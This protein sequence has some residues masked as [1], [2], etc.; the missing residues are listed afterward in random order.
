MK[1][2]LI[3]CLMITLFLGDMS[4]VYAKETVM[5]PEEEKITFDDQQ[6]SY[7]KKKYANI[8]KIYYFYSQLDD[9]NQEIYKALYQMA[10]D[11]NVDHVYSF[12]IKTS[13]N[14]A[15]AIR[16]L[17]K[18]LYLAEFAVALDHP[19][20]VTYY[21]NLWNKKDYFDDDQEDPIL[22]SQPSVENGYI[23]SGVYY[24]SH[25]KS[26]KKEE[27]QLKE[28]AIQFLDTRIN[29]DEPPA[30]IAKQ[31]HDELIDQV[32]YDNAAASLSTISLAHT[33]FGALHNRRAVC[34]GYALAYEYL[35]Q[36]EGITACVIYGSVST[37]D[38]MQEH[39]WNET[40]LGDDWYETDVTWDD[41]DDLKKDYTYYNLTSEQMASRID[42]GVVVN[43]KRDDASSDGTAQIAPQAKGTHFSKAYMVYQNY[44][45]DGV[46]PLGNP[47]SYFSVNNGNAIALSSDL[48]QTEWTITLQEKSDQTIW[49]IETQVNNAFTVEQNWQNGLL[50][51]KRNT[52]TAGK[53]ALYSQVYFDNGQRAE[54]DT[55][56]DL[57]V[58]H[59]YSNVYTVDVAPTCLQAGSESIH[60][61]NDGSIKP[62]SERMIAPL[63]HDYGSWYKIDDQYDVCVCKRDGDI[64]KALH[65]FDAGLIKVWPT[66][67]QKGEKVYTCQKCGTQKIEL[68]S[69]L[70]HKYNKGT[71]MKAA[72]YNHKGIKVYVCQRCHKKKYVSIA[73]L[74]RKLMIKTRKGWKVISSRYVVKNKKVNLK[75]KG[76]QKVQWKSSNKKLAAVKKGKVV[77]KKKGNVVISAFCQKKIY[78]L[79][80]L[81]R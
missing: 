77:F 29:S 1:K 2:L 55:Q 72:N 30:V 3:F 12:K 63:G 36:L 60:D 14:Q 7:K 24:T 69:P 62:G 81:Y 4:S 47:L 26:Y 13:L 53:G 32:Q 70:G 40:K 5:L 17:K 28:S 8:S 19:E 25:Y 15:E 31:I 75:L 43:H 80:L 6:V 10:L 18:R 33:A 48:N 34:D 42:E 38:M 44:K 11:E 22:A 73:M 76:G 21:M 49:K 78:K 46:D 66:C 56:V 41:L 58:I 23:T 59:V 71:I 61:M 67:T 27:E 64:K 52:N 35:C 74:K 39:A 50:R 68:L 57:P 51:V 79:K 65:D 45:L 37:D 16:D 9:S 54:I 20:L